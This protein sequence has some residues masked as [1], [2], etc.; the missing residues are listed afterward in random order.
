[1]ANQEHNVSSRPSLVRR[2]EGKS[3]RGSSRGSF[4]MSAS[5]H[6]K[7]FLKYDSDGNGALDADEALQALSELT[8]NEVTFEQISTVLGEF[9][10]DGNGKIDMSEFA[11]MANFLKEIGDDEDK[12]TDFASKLL[13]A[14]A[15]SKESTQD[16]LDEVSSKLY[17]FRDELGLE[18]SNR[19]NPDNVFKMD[20]DFHPAFAPSDMRCLALVSHNEMKA[21]MKHFVILHKNILKK[22]RLTGTNSTMTMLKEVFKGDNSV[23]FGPSCQSGPL[24]GDAELVAMM[25]SGGLGGMLFFQDPMSSHPHQS[26]IDCLLRQALVHNVMSCNTP[27][28]GYMLM[29][30][31]RTALLGQGR[32]ELIPS[33]FFTL[34]S[35]AV[36][37][38]KVA[39]KKVVASHSAAKK[40]SLCQEFFGFWSQ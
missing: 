16:V 29:H 4:A 1:M 37:A 14:I 38:Y 23:V 7:M 5:K 27:V 17:P 9:D 6:N 25:C 3:N 12:E 26:D 32:P 19:K 35:P 36:V 39:Q 20:E 33:F 24:G 40:S 15:M 11:V 2:A 31:L 28:T 30:T 13:S 21:T 34:Q 10:K 8:G 22:F 18:S